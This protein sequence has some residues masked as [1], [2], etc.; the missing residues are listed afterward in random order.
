MDQRRFDNIGETLY[1]DVLPNG[2]RLRVNSRP[3]FATCYA[4]FAANYGGANR[5]FRC[6]GEWTDTPAGVAHFLE[7]KMF[8]MPDGDNALDL[9]SA[10]GA[11]PNAFTSSGMTC[12]YFESTQKFY[13]NLRLLLKF[14]S[15]PYFTP[16]SVAKEQGIIGQEI[17]M[18]EDTPDFAVYMNLLKLLYARHPIRDAV[19]GT[20]ESIAEISPETLYSCHKVF[21]NPSNMTLCCAGDIDAEKVRAVA[22]EALQA[23]RGCVPE[24]DFGEA[25]ADAPAANYAEDRM[26]VS[27]PQFLIGAKASPAL[28]GDGFLRQKL[29]GQLALRILCGTSSPFYTGLYAKG[30]LNREYD[31]E[32]DWSAGTGTVIIGGESREPGAVLEQFKA[33]AAGVAGSGIS[34]QDFENALRASY[35]ARLRGLEDF[36]NV[37]VSLAE[38]VFGGYDAFDSFAM[39]RSVTPEECAEFVRDRLAPDKLAMSVILP[40][41]E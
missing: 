37:C 8:D 19:A 39:L 13:D 7:H 33:A 5:R 29:V 36:D 14:V 27:A 11:E 32:L 26:D 10:N 4:A 24:T 1:T 16:E 12:Y 40:E 30:L 21:Y 35:G 18:T 6:G 2:L 15:T 25:E 28:S 41:K 9:L 34:G 20:V 3:G 17:R 38:G 31:Y 22:E 23:E